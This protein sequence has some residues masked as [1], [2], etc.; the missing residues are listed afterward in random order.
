MKKIWPALLGM[1]IYIFSALAFTYTILLEATGL[2]VI[3][4][5]WDWYEILL[6]IILFGFVV[7]GIF[8]WKGIRLMIER[9]S[10]VE[11]QLSIAKDAFGKALDELFV[12]W[13]LSKTEIEIARLT[14]KGMSLGEIAEIRQTKIGTIKSQ[15]SA[16]YKKAG[17]NTRSQLVS[18]VI[19]EL[20]N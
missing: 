9:N 15:S 16:I 5:P 2:E 8:I 17:V 19:E 6:L 1:S 11:Q 18:L 13:D 7:G 20:M 4:I 12:N 14:F 10:L 3:A